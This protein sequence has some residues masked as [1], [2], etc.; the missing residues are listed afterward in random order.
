VASTKQLPHDGTDEPYW[1]GN[2]LA[3]ARACQSIRFGP[4]TWLIKAREREPFPINGPF[5]SLL[6]LYSWTVDIN[7]QRNKIL[8]SELCWDLGVN[9]QRFFFS[10]CCWYDL[11][12]DYPRLYFNIIREKK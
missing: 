1:G 3:E 8:S 5:V 10:F 6:A 12:I 7:L 2:N 4:A 11:R 9:T